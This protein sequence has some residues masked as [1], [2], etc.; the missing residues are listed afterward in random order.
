MSKGDVFGTAS[1]NVQLNAMR[2]H[3]SDISRLLR[4]LH[5]PRYGN[6]ERLAAQMLTELTIEIGALER[7]RDALVQADLEAAR[8]QIM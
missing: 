2:R 8:G 3:Q 7:L 5:E 6:P 1:L 4:A